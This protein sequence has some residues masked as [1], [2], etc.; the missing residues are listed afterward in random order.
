MHII[1]EHTTGDHNLAV[2]SGY[3][4]TRGNQMS[5]ARM[6]SRSDAIAA[7]AAIAAQEGD[8]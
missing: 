8:P 5:P 1:W 4:S 7:I 6:L 2:D 3:R